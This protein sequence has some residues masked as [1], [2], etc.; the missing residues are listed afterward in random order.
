M[1]HARSKALHFLLKSSTKPSKAVGSV[2]VQTVW[3]DE[4]IFD[5]AYEPLVLQGLVSLSGEK[6][7]QISVNILRDAGPTQSFTLELVLPFSLQTTCGTYV[8]IQG[9]DLVVSRV[10]LHTI[11][12]QCS[13]VT[14]KSSLFV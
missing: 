11:H 1:P 13:L 10:P 7:N 14:V 2:S 4:S 3:S 8:L 5:T 12:L 6:E 9:I